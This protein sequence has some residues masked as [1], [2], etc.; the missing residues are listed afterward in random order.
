MSASASARWWRSDGDAIV[1]ELCPQMCR[2]VHDQ[3]A[4]GCG[5]RYRSGAE[6]RTR[7][8]G[9][10]MVAH[11]DPIEKKPLYHVLPG[12]ATFSLGMRGCNLDCRHCQNWTLSA[13]RR[14]EDPPLAVSPED[15]AAEALR[16]G[17]AS[18]AFTYNEP[19]I[20][21]EF[22][23]EVARECRRRS[24]RV[25][26]VTNGYANPEVAREFFAHMDAANVDLKSFSDRFYVRI[27]RG[28]LRPVLRT[29]EEI[30]AIGTCF[31]EITTLLIPGRNDDPK[32]LEALGRWVV[33]HLGADTPLHV[34]AFHPDHQLLDHPPTTPA[35]I[36]LARRVLLEQGLRFVYSGNVHDPAG[37]STRCP[38]CGALLLERSGF[39]VLADHLQD[40]NCPSCGRPIPGLWR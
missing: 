5:V 13:D 20:S 7:A 19:L 40:G 26:A 21:A 31:L 29:L 23:I 11:L 18:V 10:A 30:R 37:E 3:D 38:D 4:G 12:S 39:T 17:A 35:Q 28:R 14:T 24:L 25:V 27:C 33:D 9:G 1:C 2:I 16:R 8:W 36:A 6:L 34:S 15:I 22:W 32:E